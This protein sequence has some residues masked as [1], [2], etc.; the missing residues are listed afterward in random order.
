[1]TRMPPYW[2]EPAERERE[3]PHRKEMKAT[4]K[5]SFDNRWTDAGL[6]LG[7][8]LTR[9]LQES[10]DGAV[11]PAVAS[12]F[13]IN[14]W[15]HVSHRFPITKTDGPRTRLLLNGKKAKISS[16]VSLLRHPR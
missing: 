16:R 12:R 15:P 9:Y 10:A 3:P 11:A 8:Q 14:G 5:K 6:R 13:L 1:M 2:R 4:R 7:G